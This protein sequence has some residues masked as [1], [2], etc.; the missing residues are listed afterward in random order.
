ME[1][2]DSHLTDFMKRLILVFFRKSVKKIQLKSD[3]NKGYFT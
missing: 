3:K 1:Q 2:L